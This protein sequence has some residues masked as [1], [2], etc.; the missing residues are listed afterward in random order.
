MLREFRQEDKHC[1]ISFI[2]GTFKKK[3]INTKM[4]G[5]GDKMGESDQN[6]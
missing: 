2:C 3:L 4:G 5:W 6:V 1:V